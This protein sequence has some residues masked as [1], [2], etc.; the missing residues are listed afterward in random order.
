MGGN[1]E[2]N[3]FSGEALGFVVDTGCS[4]S[5][6]N[7]LH[8]LN[9]F[10]FF[11]QNEG[12][13]VKFFDGTKRKIQGSGLLRLKLK[14]MVITVKCYYLPDGDIPLI[15]SAGQLEEKGIFVNTLDKSL[16]NNRGEKVEN[17]K[18][19]NR[20]LV[21]ENSDVICDGQTK[22]TDSDF[23][24]GDR[25]NRYEG[26]DDIL[27]EEDDGWDATEEEHLLFMDVHKK[28]GHLPMSTIHELNKG[29]LLVNLKQHE[30][31]EIRPNSC[32]QCSD[33]VVAKIKQKNH[34]KGSMKKFID[35]ELKVKEFCKNIS[36][37][38]VKVYALST[39]TS[40]MC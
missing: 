9:D 19:Q 22:T 2:L 34:R 35:E 33:C 8:W 12:D 20:I 26:G 5:I 16:M 3:L 17:L 7:K 36:R 1:T 32:D 13:S 24:D 37:F 30:K 39:S 38:H 27:Y 14:Q 4:T 21:L 40:N 10:Q 15:L 6:T 25:V 18:F 31:D 11:G 23:N 28:L 29:G